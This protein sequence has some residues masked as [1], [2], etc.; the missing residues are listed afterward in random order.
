MVVELEQAEVLVEPMGTFSHLVRSHV[1]A[2]S[3]ARYITISYAGRLLRD[4]ALQTGGM[5]RILNWCDSQLR[6]FTIA[7]ST[8]YALLL[9]MATMCV[10]HVLFMYFII[11]MITFTFKLNS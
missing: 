11:F 10:H 4:V 3:L 2:Y 7:L 9:Y 6:I 5:H 8:V 1:C